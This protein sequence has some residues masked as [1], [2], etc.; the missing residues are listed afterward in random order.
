MADIWSLPLAYM[1]QAVREKIASRV[2]S[3]SSETF[4]LLAEHLGLSPVHI[5]AIYNRS[6]G[7]T[8]VDSSPTKYLFRHLG[9]K[10]GYT[11]GHVQRALLKLDGHFAAD[12][13][14]DDYHQR[15]LAR[16][17]Q[18]H[19]P[20]YPETGRSGVPGSE[21]SRCNCPA[22]V[23]QN[24]RSTQNGESTPQ[25]RNE[26]G[27]CQDS[28]CSC[29][30]ARAPTD[31]ERNSPR[32]VKRSDSFEINESLA[33]EVLLNNSEEDFNPLAN[34]ERRSPDGSA[35]FNEIDPMRLSF[36]SLTSS[37]EQEVD[38]EETNIKTP[39]SDRTNSKTVCSDETNV[40]RTMSSRDV[41][42][43]NLTLD[44]K[45][46]KINVVCEKGEHG[47]GLAPNSCDMCKQFRLSLINSE[48]QPAQL[49]SGGNL[50]NGQPEK[51]AVVKRKAP[52]VDFNSAR[53]SWPPRSFDMQPN[54]LVDS[55][56][57]VSDKS[58]LSSARYIYSRQ[59]AQESILE[60]N[61]ERSNCSRIFQNNLDIDEHDQDND[62]EHVRNDRHTQSSRLNIQQSDSSNNMISNNSAPPPRLLSTR[63]DEAVWA[64]RRKVFVTYSWN[65]NE[66]D[67][68]FLEEVSRLCGAIDRS[69][70]R[71]RI[72]CDAE[73]FARRRLNRLD[74]LDHQYRTADWI[75]VCIS[76]TYSAD[77][78]PDNNTANPRESQLNTRSIYDKIRLEYHKN[79]SR[80]RRAI[81]VLFS[82][83]GTT[84]NH[85]PDCM[86]T[87]I[88]FQY[89][90]HENEIVQSIFNHAVPFRDE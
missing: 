84:Q 83:F 40:K 43:S 31:R 2:D 39:A 26:T 29:G 4:F 42:S 11:V 54:M 30:E 62:E 63:S 74:W 41:R 35:N 1:P 27:R 46:R 28:H 68:R 12:V 69:G 16:S 6:R 21:P 8:T 23:S 17:L 37:S 50:K 3:S 14:Q 53:N 45:I 9:C 81:P 52:N 64:K 67:V 57:S 72:D 34:Y 87:T 10:C 79:N 78:K 13:M 60:S 48:K 85:V 61:S 20:R 80:N 58:S 18:M 73:S 32:T 71:I 22:C 38:S 86:S 89:P 36:S 77:I 33:R 56:K 15:L 59:P 82:N 88:P 44:D 65:A 75:L 70:A 19:F 51:D 7:D 76:P 90:A 55:E 47:L 49:K 66:D 5:S 25:S 24:A